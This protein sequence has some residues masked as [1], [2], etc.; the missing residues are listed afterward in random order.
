MAAKT[1]AEQLVSVQAAIEAIETRGQSYAI[2]D[3][4]LRR[5]DLPA[6]Y[7]RE[8]FLRSQA[9]RETAGGGVRVRYGTPVR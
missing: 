7:A 2:G 6:L 1:Y 9:A 4:T 5:G 3:R 8:K